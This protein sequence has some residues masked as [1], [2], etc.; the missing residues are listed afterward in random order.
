MDETYIKQCDCPEVRSLWKPKPGDRIEEEGILWHIDDIDPKG[1][2]SN[3]KEFDSYADDL[4]R[5]P[6]A[7]I[8]LPRQEDIQE[9]LQ[10]MLSGDCWYETH[11]RFYEWAGRSQATELSAWNRF[12][13]AEHLWLAFYMHEVHNKQWTERGWEGKDLVDE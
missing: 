10:E 2:L 9:M 3:Q 12:G 6:N 8:W 4:V 11:F 13:S 5:G 7:C 1:H